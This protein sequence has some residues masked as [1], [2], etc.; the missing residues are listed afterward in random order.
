MINHVKNKAYTVLEIME[1]IISIMVALS[2]AVSVGYLVI[3]FVGSLGVGNKITAMNGF[4]GEAFT[5]VIGI[6]FVKMLCKHK[7]STVVEVLMFAIA[8]QMVVEHTNSYENLVCVA[9]IAILFAIRRFLFAS[10]DEV[11]K[12]V[13]SP[14]TKVKSVNSIC[15]VHI[16]YENDHST[17]IEVFKEKMDVDNSFITKGTS[18]FFTDVALRIS[19]IR[20]GEIKE[21]EV[22]R[23]VNHDVAHSHL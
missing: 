10:Y 3:E 15:S 18:I 13:F 1:V 17:L 20:S 22:I 5:I 19:K 16:P 4:I 12:T 11:E 21:I 6:E 7:A 8:R 14:S 2:I 23:S 9:S